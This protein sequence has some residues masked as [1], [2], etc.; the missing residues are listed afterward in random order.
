MLYGLSISL[1]KSAPKVHAKLTMRILLTVLLLAVFAISVGAA[2]A[3]EVILA[4]TTSTADTGLLD[5]LIPIF[6]Q[7]TGYM[8]KTIAVGTGQALA[9]GS[10]GEADALLC[11]APASELE[12]VKNGDVIERKLVMHNDF[13]IVGPASD[14]AKVRGLKSAA[15]AFSR[16]SGTQSVFVSRGDDSGTHKKEKAVWT[17]LGTAPSGKWYVEA[18]AGMGRT[19]SIAS[20]KDGYTL[21]DRGTY[22]AFQKNLAL[23]I[24]VEG[25]AI[26]LS[27]Y[28]VMQVNPAKFAKVN[29]AGGLAFAEFMVS[30]EVQEI[31]STFGVDKY[32][33]P[34]FFPDAGKNVDDLGK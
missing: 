15:E 4:T 29:G 24:L 22:L 28:H 6:Q 9:L 13:I 18:G 2:P 5:V 30:P 17:K 8:V 10:R 1:P 20:E 33:D 21:T 27:I 25:D 19:L 31:I 12:L 26:L 16:I 3:R 34:L 7:K 11:H 23:D 32:G 14:P